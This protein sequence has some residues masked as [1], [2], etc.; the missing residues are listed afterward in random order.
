MDGLKLNKSLFGFGG[1]MLMI[2]AMLAIVVAYLVVT[3][4]TT[5]VLVAL[6]ATVVVALTA[7]TPYVYMR[8]RCAREACERA[9]LRNAATTNN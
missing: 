7:G 2:A 5:G 1:A 8:R 6:L 9:A 4:A 3:Y